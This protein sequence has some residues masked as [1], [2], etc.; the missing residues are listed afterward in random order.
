[1]GKRRES[2]NPLL[3]S[4]PDSQK[5][6]AV[7]EGAEVL[8]VRLIAAA[9]DADR[10]YGDAAYVLA[11]LFTARLAAGSL[12]ARDIEKR[13]AELE[14]VGLLRFYTVRGV[15]YV[16][17][18]DRFK[19]LRKDV[20]PQV[21]F[22]EPLPENETD[23]LRPRNEIVPLDPDP[24]PKESTNV[25]SSAEAKLDGPKF[26]LSEFTF[27]TVGRGAK[28]WTLPAAKLREYLESYPGVDVTAELT[29]ARQWCRD[30]S[31]NRKTPNG[32]QAFLTRWLNKCQNTARVAAPSPSDRIAKSHEL[33]GWN[34]TTGISEQ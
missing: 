10:Y 22:P 11:K 6:N 5:I 25:D 14:S 1:M 15:R 2:Y 30:N 3:K 12:T 8:Y 19:T 9:D 18:L 31:R 16:Q 34:S 13:L 17:L 24:D 21:V 4:Y 33:Q 32:M 23:A 27:P 7:S 28:T 26:E 20:K 29:K